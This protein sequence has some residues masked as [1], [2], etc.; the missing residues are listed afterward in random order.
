MIPL[1]R[2]SVFALAL[3]LAPGGCDW[4]PADLA[5][6]GFTVQVLEPGG[7]PVA[8]AHLTGGIDWDYFDVATDSAG[9]ALLPRRARHVA[10]MIRAENHIAAPV[11][12][13]EPGSYH[14]QP[15][16]GRVHLVGGLWGNV[17]SA[18]G[19]EAT[20][21]SLDGYL[22]RFAYSDA[23]VVRTFELRI[24]TAT[25]INTA[26]VERDTLWLADGNGHLEAWSL[27]NPDQP[28]K[29]FALPILVIDWA[30]LDSVRIGGWNTTAVFTYSPA[31]ELRML[32]TLSL[33]PLRQ[34]WALD[35]THALL[36]AWAY[37]GDPATVAVVDATNP[38]QPR[39]A[40]RQD[41]PG[42]PRTLRGPKPLEPVRRALQRL[43]A[44][45]R[46]RGDGVAQ[47]RPLRSFGGF[48]HGRANHAFS[49]ALSDAER[50][51]SG[52]IHT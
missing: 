43:S 44:A 30:T 27:A 34:A 40:F 2:L 37:V 1:R 18:S 33:P 20:T 51:A 39:V 11:A 50:R 47:E 22:R 16:P 48:A 26:R 13:L 14:L 17:V 8:A 15:T 4:L 49:A 36:V 31:G 41:F 24:D 12:A 29:L 7:A 45:V 19:D 5:G 35:R 42:A 32:A 3:A 21:V 10:A 46:Q 9:E 28:R 6:T 25:S 23:G 52:C 38:R